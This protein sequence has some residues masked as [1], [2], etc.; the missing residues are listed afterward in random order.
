[1]LGGSEAVKRRFTALDALR[2]FIIWHMVVFHGLYDINVIGGHNPCWPWETH[3]AA[4]Q[5]IGLCIFVMLAGMSFTLMSVAKR[6]LHGLKLNAM[7]LAITAVT[8]A[9]IPEEVIFFGVLSFMGC[10]V[11]VTMLLENSRWQLL[12]SI[13]AAIGLATCLLLYLVTMHINDG[14]LALGGWHL[15]KLPESLYGS[16]TAA[17]GFPGAEFASADYVPLLPYIFIYW[18]GGFALRLI[19]HYCTDLLL[20]MDWPILLWPGKHSLAIYL[21]HQPILLFIL[22]L[23]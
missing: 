20:T 21:V 4:W 12:S 5:E 1:M 15:I 18:A 23:L 3:I 2:G 8:Y 9:M 10:A 17:L 22:G 6:F 14:Y 7:G 19:K 11:W 16:L 13:P